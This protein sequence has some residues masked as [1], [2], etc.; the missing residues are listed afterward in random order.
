MNRNLYC[1]T[2]LD[3][4]NPDRQ[5]HV[6]RRPMWQ[7]LEALAGKGMLAAQCPSICLTVIL[8]TRSC[9]ICKHVFKYHKKCEANEQI[10]CL[11]SSGK[12]VAHK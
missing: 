3:R 7:S 5:R 11:F 8:N 10:K 9:H 12:L 6:R 4:S 2:I 1:I